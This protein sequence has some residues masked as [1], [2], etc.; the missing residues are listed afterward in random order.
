MIYFNNNISFNTQ[1]PE[2]G[3]NCSLL[4]SKLKTSFNTQPPE[5]GWVQSLWTHV[6]VA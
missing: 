4:I 3:W 6:R 5:G 2:G 1:P